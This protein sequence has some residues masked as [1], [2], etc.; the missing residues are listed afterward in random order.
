M[1]LGTLSIW[2]D[3]LSL[4]RSDKAFGYALG[5]DV[6][7]EA[8]LHEKVGCAEDIESRSPD[9]LCLSFVSTEVCGRARGTCAEENGNVLRSI[10]GWK[11]GSV[12]FIYTPVFAV[13]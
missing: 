10:E 8:I 2:H 3:S 6:V 13:S 7:P 4:Y 9:D 12:V 5:I 1:L 11:E